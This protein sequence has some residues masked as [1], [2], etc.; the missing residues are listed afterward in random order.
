MAPKGEVQ[1]MPISSSVPD[2]TPVIIA[3]HESGFT[4][5]E[6]LVTLSIIALI[7][8]LA[9]PRIS[10]DLPASG[11][12]QRAALERAIAAAR[13]ESAASGEVQI[14]DPAASVEGARL[15]PSIGS[16]QSLRFYPDGSSNGGIVWQGKKAVLRVDWLTGKV[17]NAA[18]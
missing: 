2:M 6:M 18:R 8:A 14:L 10:G 15:D 13:A 17:R 11:Y 4:L 12:A 9:L 3:D 1:R 5:I 7:A 16:E